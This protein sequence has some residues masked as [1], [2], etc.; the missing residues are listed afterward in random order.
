MELRYRL[1][2]LLGQLVTNRRVA[3]VPSQPGIRLADLLERGLRRVAFLSAVPIRVVRL[4][5]RRWAVGGG[6][7]AVGVGGGRWAVSGATAVWR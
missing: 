5:Q 3:A 7:W 1:G 6:R 2:Y 4:A